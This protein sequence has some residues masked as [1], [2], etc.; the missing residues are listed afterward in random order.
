M[1][2]YITLESQAISKQILKHSE[3][4]RWLKVYRAN[5]GDDVTHYLEVVGHHASLAT[6]RELELRIADE[7]A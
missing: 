2:N 1:I 4:L 7:R 3:A 5:T 6:L